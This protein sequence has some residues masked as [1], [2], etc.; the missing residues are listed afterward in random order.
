[1][2][3]K[4]KKKVSEI[5][6]KIRKAKTDAE[7]NYWL[8]ILAKTQSEYEVKID[9]AFKTCQKGDFGC[10]S[11]NQN[12][13]G[14]QGGED[15]DEDERK[16]K[17]RAKK[18]SKEK[19]SEQSSNSQGNGRKHRS[20]SSKN[21]KANS[22]N[23]ENSHNK[24]QNITSSGTEVTSGGGG[25]GSSAASGSS[26]TGNEA[27]AEEDPLLRANSLDPNEA[28][29]M[30]TP[31]VNQGSLRDKRPTD[32][33]PQHQSGLAPTRYYSPEEL[34]R[35]SLKKKEDLTEEELLALEEMELKNQQKKADPYQQRLKGSERLRGSTNKAAV[36]LNYFAVQAP[37]GPE[38]LL[39]DIQ[40]SAAILSHGNSLNAASVQQTS[41]F[42]GY[43]SKGREFNSNSGILPA[44]SKSGLTNEERSLL[45]S[46]QGARSAARAGEEKSISSS[47]SKS[48]K[49]ISLSSIANV[50]PNERA[51]LRRIN[52]AP[53]TNMEVHPAVNNL[54]SRPKWL[55]YL[56]KFIS[57]SS[58]LTS[59]F[60]HREPASTESK[61]EEQI[62][63]MHTDLFYNINRAYQFA[64]GSLQ[65]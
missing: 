16:K 65:K 23:A 62:A 39:A 3:K 33:T 21:N 26:K 61:D 12:N 42:D 25:A 20:Q 8:G 50:D 60:P 30:G 43:V 48:P 63:G 11:R 34:K 1:M 47:K 19:Y 64:G 41:V 37:N 29:I 6:E 9:Q 49:A 27:S 40:K 44:K 59:I 14:E 31:P 51:P 22:Q 4:S 45:S 13:F 52:E 53:G 32:I 38:N 10:L 24:D 17:A 2:V 58:I 5:D 57:D 15:K 18:K 36:T 55:G 35:L 56:P 7:R 28:P 54:S 46:F